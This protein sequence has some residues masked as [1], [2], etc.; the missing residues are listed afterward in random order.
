[1]QNGGTYLHILAKEY[2]TY[3]NEKTRKHSRIFWLLNPNFYNINKLKPMFNKVLKLVSGF[4]TKQL[5]LFHC[6]LVIKV[7]YETMTE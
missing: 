5:Y 6:V 2:I 3:I 7:G 4:K 1:M